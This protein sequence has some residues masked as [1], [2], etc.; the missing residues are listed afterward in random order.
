MES[1][2]ISLNL[3]DDMR[4]VVYFDEIELDS[5]DEDQ[6]YNEAIKRIESKGISKELVTSWD[7]ETY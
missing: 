4:L 3:K 5:I 7:I 2:L 1:T 6:L